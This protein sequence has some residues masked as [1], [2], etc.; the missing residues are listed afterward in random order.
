MERAD[1]TWPDQQR[2]GAPGTASANSLRRPV[3]ARRECAF[4]LIPRSPWRRERSSCHSPRSHRGELPYTLALCLAIL[5]VVTLANLRGTLDAGRLFA[6]PTYGFV[7]SF[8]LILMIGVYKATVAGG[9][10]HP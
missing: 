4:T 9:T 1:K 2:C 5:V 8:L 7:A 6:L 10:P 3:I